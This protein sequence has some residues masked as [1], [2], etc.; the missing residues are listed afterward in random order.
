MQGA[1]R[2]PCRG[3]L[4]RQKSYGYIS[5]EPKIKDEPICAVSSNNQ[6]ECW[7]CG[8]GNFT[9]YHL[10]KCKAPNVMCNYCGRK[11]HLERVCNQKTKEC[12]LKVGNS[13]GIGKRVQRVDTEESREEDDEDYMVLKVESESET[14][15]PYYME[16]FMNGNNFKTMKD[17]RLPS[18]HL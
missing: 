14:A 2:N 6:R 12:N 15:K 16:G 13:R 17:N 3:T 1:K 7:R 5:Q 11:G 8:A 18:N 4:K 10:S 9:L